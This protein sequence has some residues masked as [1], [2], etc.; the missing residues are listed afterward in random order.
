MGR[1]VPSLAQLKRHGIAQPIVGHT[2]RS[3]VR[4]MCFDCIVGLD[5][6]HKAKIIHRDIKPQNIL[7]AEC[8]K[9]FYCKLADMGMAKMIKTNR[10]SFDSSDNCG[11][12]FWNAPELLLRHQKGETKQRLT[13]KIDIFSLGCVLFFFLCKGRHP[14]GDQLADQLANMRSN[15]LNLQYL[16]NAVPEAFDL[17]RFMLAIRA[18]N[19]LQASECAKHLFFWKPERTLAFLLDFSDFIEKSTQKTNELR[20]RLQLSTNE[21]V[22]GNDW[23]CF[24]DSDLL[25]DAG[26]HRKYNANSLRDFLRLMRNKWNHFA[27]LDKNLQLKLGHPDDGRKSAKH[28]LNYF[29]ERMPFLVMRCYKLVATSAHIASFRQYFDEIS[30]QRIAKYKEEVRVIK[31]RKWMAK[32]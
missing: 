17:L 10:L 14:F 5:A 26:K 2:V 13:Q 27:E 20:I 3:S 32:C 21:I 19:R 7:I 18:S 29:L 15:N 6:L 28:F 25:R 23:T 31:F 9:K 1:R 8:D 4:Q 30:P 11:T 24:V 12:H 22:C 16:Q